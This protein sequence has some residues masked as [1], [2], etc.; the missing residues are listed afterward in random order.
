[1]EESPLKKI[2][3]PKTLPETAGPLVSVVTPT[4]DD[5]EYL[6]DGL[7]SLANQSYTNLEVVVVD[8]SGVEWLATLVSNLEWGRYIYE[9]PHGVAA[10]RNRGLDAAE[11]EIIAFLDADD[12]YAR[13][14]IERQVR[15]LSS[16]VDF[17]YSNVYI[18][19]NDRVQTELDA[20]PVE[21]PDTH[22]I[23]FFKT[24][25]G[26]PTVTV[27]ANRSC[28]YDERFDENFDARE[29]PHLWTR[30]FKHCTPA[31][32]NDPLAYKRRRE[33][34]L[35]A[36]PDRMY[37]CEIAEIRD[38]ADRFEELRPFRESR[39]RRA[40]FRYAKHLLRAGRPRKSKRVLFSV[41]R[42]GFVDHRTIALLIVTLLPVGSKRAFDI[43]E[44]IQQNLRK[45][46]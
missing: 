45:W 20:L 43:L 12:F 7:R 31:K 38:L 29:D 42:S 6:R 23:D 14:K 28:F 39:E 10:A 27:A 30:L 17:V 46:V 5:A 4:Y 35:T 18:V 9:P 21:N 11:G 3:L 24:G 34:S 44:R 37:K 22:H 16:E 36:D 40:T 33:D 15:K 19:E 13:E 32:I 2:S 25:Q 8:S 1:M 26:V 41:M